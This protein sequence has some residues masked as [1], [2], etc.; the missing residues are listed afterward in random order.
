MGE[1]NEANQPRYL[2]RTPLPAV[3]WDTFFDAVGDAFRL[4]LES[5]GPPGHKEPILVSE[6][7]KTN[8]GN[9]D[10]SFDVILFHMVRSE[11]AAMDPSGRNRIPK[12]PTRREVKPHPCKARYSLVTIGWWELMTTRFSVHS[13]SRDRA[14][15]VTSWFHRMMMRYTFDLSFFKARGVHYMTFDHR[16]EDEFTREYGQEIYVRTLDY[17]VRLELLQS[18]EVKDIESFDIQI[19][20]QETHLSEQYPIPK[21]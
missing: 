19:A 4:H 5:A 8:E 14:D 12:G 13:L 16:G 6:F 9:F 7:P 15:Q 17:N 20:D 10:T 1:V 2:T 18:F 21:P 3:D 11:R